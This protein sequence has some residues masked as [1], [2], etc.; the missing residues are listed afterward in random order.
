MPSKLRLKKIE[1]RFR[2]EMSEMLVRQEISDP[3]LAGVTITDV[4][5]DR[6]LAFASIYVSAL[7]GS[8]RSKE[9]LEGF[10]SASGYIRKLLASRIEL[11]SF[12]RLRFYWD[13]TPERADRI[14][15]I[16]ASIRDEDNS[17]YSN[18]LEEIDLDDD[19][20]K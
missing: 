11:R 12:P 14:E 2:Q 17:D 19:T 1:D 5:I 8:E 13:P 15:E 6:E 3:R 10:E 7:E 9:V 18:N 4:K 20:V 16:L